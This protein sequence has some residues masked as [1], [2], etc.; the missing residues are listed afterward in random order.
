MFV[1]TTTIKHNNNLVNVYYVDRG[2]SIKDTIWSDKV[3]DALKFNTVTSAESFSESLI[4]ETT[5]R[6]V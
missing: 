3:H 6:D 2:T 5:V 4:E 1:I